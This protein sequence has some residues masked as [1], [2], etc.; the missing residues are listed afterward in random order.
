VAENLV[1][2]SLDS[3]LRQFILKRFPLARKQ[4]VKNSD[5]LLES[6]MLDSLGI[7][8]VVAFMEQTFSVTISDEDLIP[9]NFLTIER[10]AAFVRQKITEI[11]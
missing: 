6:G 5:A 9:D 3:D 7:L 4:Q 8:E 1:S 10:M 11:V 2:P